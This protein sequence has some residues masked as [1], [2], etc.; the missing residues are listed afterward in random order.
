MTRPGTQVTLRDTPP[1]RSEPE[2]TG[3]WFVCGLTERGKAEPDFVKS[4]DAF[5]THFGDRQSYSVLYDCIE[6]FFREGGNKVWISRVLGPNPV[7][8]FVDLNDSAPAATLRVS[9]NSPGGWGNSLNVAVTAG[10]AVGEFKL[11]IS[12]DTLGTLETSPSLVDTTAAISWAAT[13]SSY[14]EL[15]ELAGTGDPVVVAAQSLAT[16]TDDRTNI[17]DA[18]WQAAVDLFLADEGPGQVSYPGQ[19]TTTLHNQ[20]MTHAADNNR[21]AILDAP[22]TTSK[23]ALIAAASPLQGDDGE[24]VSGLFAPWV[25]IPGLLPNTEREIPYSP[26]Q[27][28]LIARSDSKSGNPNLAAA[29]ENGRSL[30]ATGVN[31]TFNSAD[32]EELNTASVNLAKVVNGEVRTYGYRTLVDPT[33]SPNYRNLANM[34][35]VMA[36]KALADDI[37][38]SYVFDQIDAQGQKF[39]EYNGQLKGMLDEFWKKRALYGAT[40]EEAFNVDTSPAVNT[41]ITIANEE[42]RA[43]LAIKASPYGEL[44][45]VEVVKVATQEAVA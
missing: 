26:I 24:R 16:G 39:A 37:A 41:P 10:D 3:V 20:Q 6:A 21:I 8:A 31:A 25:T 36:I 45:V 40:R 22:D 1:P 13:N 14:V 28:G 43:V 44:V 23:S 34:R 2:A 38:E 30:L 7:T 15:T 29:G 18:E 32:R 4:L 17:T 12:H 27:A 19:T 42:I 11:V 9:A 35:L 5:I 33:T